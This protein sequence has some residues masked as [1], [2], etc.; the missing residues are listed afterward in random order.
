VADTYSTLKR[1]RPKSAILTPH[2]PSTL[3]QVQKR[4]GAGVASA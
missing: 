3:G 4:Q 2:A 1:E